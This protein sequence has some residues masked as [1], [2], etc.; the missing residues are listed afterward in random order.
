MASALVDTDF[1]AARLGA[2]DAVIIDASW[3]MP[4]S[5]GG[6]EDDYRA[7]HI[8][9]AVFFD[10]DRIADHTVDLPHML[11]KESDFAAA[12]G[13]MG[14]TEDMTAI[15]YDSAG[16]FSAPRVWWT[17]RAFG[18]GDVRVLDGGL[19]RWKAEG[20][21]L[22]SGVTQR[23]PRRFTATYD[24]SLVFG[25]RD[26]LAALAARNVQIIDA[27]ARDRFAGEAPEPR[28]GLRAGHIPGSLNLPWTEL[29]DGGR[30]L[31][32]ERL[33]AAFDNAGVDW[34][35]SIATTCGSGVSASILSLALNEIGTP[36]AVYDGSWAEW[37]ARADLPVEG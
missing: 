7:A 32:K 4:G 9:G 17:L 2:A 10:I 20:R 23:S 25:W 6:G 21:P 35:K 13:A 3:K 31:G 12:M 8:P 18:M 29:L 26:A 28:P 14:V 30:F 27:R 24:A 22:E 11:P 15:V 36:S 33:R 1:V 37:G 16:V 5:E 34:R 19:P